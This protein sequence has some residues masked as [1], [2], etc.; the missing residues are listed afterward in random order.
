MT[1]KDITVPTV[2]TGVLY[3]VLKVSCL[4]DLHVIIYN[5]ISIT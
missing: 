1:I 4:E 2:Q 3:L 5:G